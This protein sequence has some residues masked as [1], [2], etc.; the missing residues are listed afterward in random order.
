M[1][2]SE[3]NDT[4][5]FYAAPATG[6]GSERQI[7]RSKT[8]AFVTPTDWSADGRF[9]LF[10]SY[11]RGDVSLLP[12]A[13]PEAAVPVVESPFTDWVASFS[14][15]GRWVAYVSDES[16][17]EEIYVKAV[18]R[19]SRYRVSVGGGTQ[20]R[21]RRDGKELFFIGPA[22]KLYAV[23][24]GTETTFD[25]DAPRPLFQ[26]CSA[27]RAQDARSSFR[28]RY[29]VAADGKRTLWICAESD[30]PPAIVAVHALSRLGTQ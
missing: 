7:Y 20:P 12:V 29:D 10:H 11:P 13:A 27:P 24:V 6:G 4:V 14:P 1:F 17:A 5:T 18:D 26:A 16:G 15:D 21:W 23:T 2:A 8:S 25:F 30:T 28:Y 19:A 22:D 3:R 9:V